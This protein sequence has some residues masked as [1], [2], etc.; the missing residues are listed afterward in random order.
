MVLPK[1]EKKLRTD[2]PRVGYSPYGQ[3]HP[4]S[5]GNRNSTAQNE[6]DNQYNNRPVA[7]FTHVVGNGRIIQVAP[8][9]RGAY[10]VGGDWNMWTYAA[11][12]IIE[13]HRTKQEF[14]ID[15][16][17]YVELLRQL[18]DE[19]GIPKKLDSGNVGINT[20]DYC[21]RYQPNNGTDHVDPYPY[22]EKWGI[23]RSQFKRDIENGLGG[24][25]VV[26][27]KVKNTYWANGSYFEALQDLKTYDK[28]FK[29]VDNT[30][31]LKKGSKFPVRNI[32][33]SSSGTTHAF[34]AG[35]DNTCVTL[36][37]SHVKKL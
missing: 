29:K 11:V 16:K 28:T 32:Q 36:A 12:E 3:I 15:Y 23:S 33:V 22:L 10:D 4:H 1:I 25:T 14:L 9:N 26:K 7:F 6:A 8:V 2:T 24:T 27:P 34:V 17:I 30:V 21:R 20:H 31:F 37:K 35:L 19:A 13:S 18:A 5:T